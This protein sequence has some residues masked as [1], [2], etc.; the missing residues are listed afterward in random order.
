M[1]LLITGGTGFVGQRLVERALAG[2]HRVMVV[3]R[4]PQR[5][6][7]KLPAAVA[8]GDSVAAFADQRP[9]G[10]V[11]LAGEPIAD[12]RW[13]DSQKTR[14]IE[15][16]RHIT[17][18]IV[19]LC[20]QL[21]QSGDAPEVLVSG[22]AMGFY[23]DQGER[24][25]TESTPPHDEF[26]HRLCEEWEREANKATEVGTRVACVRI[27]L[28]LDADG[29]TLARLL[30]VFKLGLGGRLGDGRQYMPWI[31]REDLVAAIEF[32]LAEPSL[33]GPFNASAPTP[34]T[35]AEF[36]RALGH[37]LKRPTPFRV[38]ATLLKLGLGEMSRLL[39]TGACMRPARL[40]AAG[41]RFTYPT[42]DTALAAILPR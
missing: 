7:R 14:L 28:V 26:A 4:Q 38:P 40:E 2:G 11:N 30:P 6:R 27:G 15:S 3:S 13:S 5:A 19:E 10:I 21:A 41:F 34:V 31:H 29:G 8:V 20:E 24:D 18:E 25:V 35:N 42:L 36:T 37:Q 32:L 17:R 1:R 9:Q 39:L 12:K 33:A 23:G 16:R 22:S